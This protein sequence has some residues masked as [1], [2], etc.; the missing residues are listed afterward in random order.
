MTTNQPIWKFAG[1]IGDVD[2]IAFG[3]A[4]VYT[5]ETGA[6]GPE[7]T[8]FE[9]ASD[10]EWHKTEGKTPLSV[11]RIVLDPPRF[12][13]LTEA[14]KRQM[15]RTAELPVSER[16]ITWHWYNEW[17]VS[18]LPNVAS[19]CGVTVMALLRGFFSK[20]AVQRAWAYESVISN[21]GVEE[22][23]QSPVTMTE[24]EA[25]AKYAEEMKAIRTPKTT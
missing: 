6:Y 12:K 11:Y 14:G 9:P 1:H 10:D 15:V 17:F 22:F 18:K 23:D 3:G 20:D 16:G 19:S 5:D 24:D 13:T 25:Y 21:F 2:P 8:W 7:M 4:F